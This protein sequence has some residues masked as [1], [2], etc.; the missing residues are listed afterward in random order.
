MKLKKLGY[1][2]STSL[3]TI[4][5]VT[6]MSFILVKISPVDPAESYLRLHG[7]MP[8]EELIQKISESMGLNQ[9]LLSQYLL[10]LKNAFTLNL[11]SS[12]V[13][14]NLVIN[15]FAETIPKTISM[16]C[17]SVMIQAILIPLI[18]CSM[19]MTKNPIVMKVLDL[20]CII[21]LSIPVFLVGTFILEIFA[22]RLGWISV[23]NSGKFWPAVCLAVPYVGVY[24]K[25][26]KTNLD[27]Q[28]KKEW[29]INARCRG[30]SETR[31][32]FLHGL[33]HSM[34]ELLPNF[35]QNVGMMI[36]YS[37]IVEVVFSYKG[38]G[39]LVIEAIRFKDIPMIHASVLF[40]AVNILFVNLFAELLRTFIK[41][42]G[43]V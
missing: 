36:A 30:Y 18:G 13:T 15:E 25:M 12:L 11:G 2:I 38:V 42:R 4:L 31:I 29:A 43:S 37:G 8:T 6:F 23:I 41:E 27:Y 1:Q 7:S 3:L 16:V 24:S 19:K 34:S 32:L 26:L 28:M 39:N 35:A 22:L 9:P 5:L 21:F 40:L 17:V 33:K 10:W 20:T 14:G